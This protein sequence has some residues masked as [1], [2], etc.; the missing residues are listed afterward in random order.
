[1]KARRKKLWTSIR[2]I[3]KSQRGEG[4]I[5]A[6][7]VVVVA[8]MMLGLAMKLFPIFMMKSQLNTF[9]VEL[10]RTAAI[11]GQVGAEVT[12]REETL[13]RE[14]GLNP[15]ITWSAAYLPST[16]RVQL[17]DPI[18]LELEQNQ[19]L[20]L[21]GGFSSFPI[22]LRSKASSRSEVFWK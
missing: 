7:V 19:D 9:A 11:T 21:F 12:A 20:G 17:D 2:T 3:L 22:T 14:T 6:A 15:V 5:E 13:R 8:V 16:S 1:V 18:T 4:T 10:S